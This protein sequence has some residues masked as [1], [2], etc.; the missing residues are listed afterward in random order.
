MR[1]SLQLLPEQPAE[2]LLEA[3]AIADELGYTAV[4]GA[5]EIYHKD[6]W[7]L[8]A[9]AAARTERVRLGPCVAPLFLRDP[10][11]VAQHAATLDEL[12]GGRAEVVF[13]IGNVAQLDQYSVAWRGTKPIA[14]LREAHTVMRTLLDE[15]RI[16]F[17][18]DFYRYAGVFTAAHPVQDHLPLKLG[19]MA[20]PRTMELAGE[21]ADGMVAACAY[22]AE[23]IGYAVEHTRTGAQRAAR[24]PDTLDIANSVLG[25]IGHDREAAVAAARVLAAFYLPSMPPA[26]L[27]RHDIPIESV[28]PVLDGFAEGDVEAALAATPADVADAIVVAGTPEDWVRWIQDVASPAGL[29]H[30]LVSFADPFTVRSWS[31]RQVDGLLPLADQIRLLHDE[32]M[33]AFTHRV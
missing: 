7:S 9:A 25:A 15:G 29:G 10:T 3:A 11:H 28:Q 30:L 5:D 19:A 17:A 1:I 27:A 31:G 8:L 24:D 14:R 23:A 6:I 18:G 33:P 2:E 21:I 32:V 4:Y 26:L 13:G 22:S 16:D 12:S 20:G